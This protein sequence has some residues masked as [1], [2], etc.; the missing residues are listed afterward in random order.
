MDHLSSLIPIE[1]YAFTKTFS[2]YIL[3]YYLHPC[4]FRL[5]CALLAC[6][7]LICSTRRTD[8]SVGLCR[9]LPNHR[10]CFYLIFSFIELT[11]ILVRISSFLTYLSSCC[12]ISNEACA[13]L[14][15][16]SFRYDI[17]L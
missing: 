15:H 1:Q 13:C 4:F 9:T 16:S 14:L 3:S 2:L 10:R 5:L 11:P 6:P 8:A 17:S 12:H 7:N